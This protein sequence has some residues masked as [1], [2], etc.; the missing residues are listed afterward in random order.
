MNYLNAF[1]SDELVYALGWTVVHSLWQALIIAVLISVIVMGFKNKSSNAKYRAYFMGLLG[2]LFLSVLTFIDLFQYGS[3]SHFQQV[4]L[5]Q[6]HA[7]L[8]I[9]TISYHESIVST[10][11]AYF[12]NNMPLIVGIWL[13]GMVFFLLR[14]LGGIACV[15]Y[16]KNNHLNTIPLAY[17]EKMWDLMEKIPLERAVNLAESTLVKVPMVIG[18]FKPIIL[19][20]FGTLNQ[21]HPD[22]IEA[23][24][25]HELAHIARNDYLINVLQSV[26]EVL[27][28][29]NPAVWWL[30]ANIRT[31][32]E[33]CC[34]DRAIELCGNS[35]TYAKALVSLQ[36][37][38]HVPPMLA[39][40]FAGKQ[41]KLLHRIQRILKQ[42]QNR[43]NIM[44]KLM[45]T[46]LLLLTIGLLSMNANANENDSYIEIN[47]DDSNTTIQI[48]TRPD[49]EREVTVSVAATD[50][51]PQR[52]SNSVHTHRE[53]VNIDD[54]DRKI[55]F[56]RINGKLTKLKI[57]G[58]TIPK[59]EW[60]DY[61]NELDKISPPEPPVPPVPPA[62]PAPPSYKKHKK[63][64][65]MQG[66]ED[67]GTYVIIEK[68]NGE[69]P[70]RIHI[71]EGEAVVKIDGKKIPLGETIIIEGDNV[72]FNGK[73]KI[74]EDE[75]L[76]DLLD[77][78]RLNFNIDESIFED[79]ANS[80]LAF[81]NIEEGFEN[82]EFDFDSDIEKAFEE[83]N[84]S[85][86]NIFD[87]ESNPFWTE[88][89]QAEL[90]ELFEDQHELF[91]EQRENAFELREEAMELLR[92][93]KDDRLE[94]M[95]HLQEN[96]NDLQLHAQEMKAFALEDYFENLHEYHDEKNNAA[97]EQI[98]RELL[99]DGLIKDRMKFKFHLTQ[100]VLKVNGKK[101]PSHI[102]K[103]YKKLY[104]KLTDF[105][106]TENFEI[107]IRYRSNSKSHSRSTS[108]EI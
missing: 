76:E 36:E 31:E 10:I 20:P 104:E 52:K 27:F 43:N 11:I 83:A 91:L 62:P 21:L 18:F 28:Y 13:S 46:C 5:V 79:I 72:N 67:G 33:N 15:Q 107:N 26:I 32:R 23:I 61:K 65:T 35:L 34:D 95:L 108:T 30:S 50:T 40:P 39:M 37:V 99:N 7:V 103:K 64:I 81:S 73:I 4:I 93:H 77:D 102:H 54:E 14:L 63:T 24:L 19:L 69:A 38:N 12:N 84:K 55:E 90:E 101:Q 80:A 88:E 48:N 56:E 47:E 9:Q 57:N 17:K 16:L 59:N 1:I 86:E 44:E 89:Q 66:E 68:H 58:E 25:A 22:E 41:P 106:I 98:G 8:E 105:N 53:T 51:I 70:T 92:Q 45:A 3:D 97:L 2:V 82:F 94:S 42:P 71:N 100:E 74:M 78:N 96:L 87:N 6:N 49:G 60:A 75:D 29:F 85:L